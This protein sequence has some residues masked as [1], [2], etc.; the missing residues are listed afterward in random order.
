VLRAHAGLTYIMTLANSDLLMMLPEKWAQ[1]PLW[2]T[3]FQAIQVKEALATR[4][5]CIVQRTGLPLT[6]AAE[7]FCDMVRREGAS[8]QA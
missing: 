1:F 3:L 6:P 4:P 7:Y 8:Y 5:I 2:G